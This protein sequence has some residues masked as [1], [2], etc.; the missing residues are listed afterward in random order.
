MFFYCFELDEESK[1]LCTINTCYGLYRYGRLPMG[2]KVSPDYAQVTINDILDGLDCKAYINDCGIWTNGSFEEH[3]ELGA[4]VLKRLNKNGL[5]CN[6]KC[7]WVVK[8]TD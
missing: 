1:D 8:E 3:L 4:K 7:D 5:K 6:P 2:V